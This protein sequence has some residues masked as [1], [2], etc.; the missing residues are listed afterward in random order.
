M[1][2]FAQLHVIFLSFYSLSAQKITVAWFWILLYVKS[3]DQIVASFFCSHLSTLVNKSSAL[4]HKDSPF[5]VQIR[6][7]VLVWNIRDSSRS[8]QSYFLQTTTQQPKK[9]FSVENLADFF[10]LC[11][12]KSRNTP[13]Y[14]KGSYTQA[15]TSRGIDRFHWNHIS[16][17]AVCW[18]V[19]WVHLH[20]HFGPREDLDGFL[21]LCQFAFHL[22]AFVANPHCVS[23][24]GEC[25][26]LLHQ[27]FL[28]CNPT[29]NQ[30]VALQRRADQQDSAPNSSL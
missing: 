19:S 26:Q 13:C 23:A 27:L 11:H 15:V 2:K 5:L 7:N 21:Q 22:L 20:K 17:T 10:V 6:S 14:R 8:W 29:Q 28:F 16:P 9:T 3:M 25:C 12:K 4:I 1:G 24:D 30:S 18:T